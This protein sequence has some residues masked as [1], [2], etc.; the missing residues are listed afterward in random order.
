MSR[1]ESGL[2]VLLLNLISIVYFILNPFAVIILSISSRHRSTAHGEEQK[3][4]KS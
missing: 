4:A 3:R 2:I 1:F